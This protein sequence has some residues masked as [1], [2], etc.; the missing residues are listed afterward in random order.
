MRHFNRYTKR[1]FTINFLICRL[2]H[3][4]T[5]AGILPSQ[6]ISFCNF[7][8][9]GVVGHWY[10]R[11]GKKCVNMSLCEHVYVCVHVE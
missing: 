10:I 6:Y 11:Q 1:I 8:G 4:F 5:C 3:A 7:A 9:M 2:V